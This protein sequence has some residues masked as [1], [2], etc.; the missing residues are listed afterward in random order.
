MEKEK[1]FEE[2]EDFE[3]FDPEVRCPFFMGNGKYELRCRGP[4]EGMSFR[5]MINSPEK[6]KEQK[7]VFCRKSYKYCEVYDCIMRAKALR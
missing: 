4:F 5:N 7:K 3:R 2:T 6:I 1:M